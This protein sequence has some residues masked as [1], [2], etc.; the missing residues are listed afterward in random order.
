MKCSDHLSVGERVC[1]CVFSAQVSL[2]MSSHYGTN[3]PGV[4]LTKRDTRF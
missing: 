4:D 1:V 3:Y 2:P